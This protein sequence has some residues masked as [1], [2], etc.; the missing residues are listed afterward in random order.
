MRGVATVREEEQDP[1]GRRAVSRERERSGLA[2][3]LLPW[4][5]LPRR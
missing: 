2:A 1:G 3:G 5:Y 4:A